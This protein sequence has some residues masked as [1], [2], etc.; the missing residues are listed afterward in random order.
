MTNNERLGMFAGVATKLVYNP[1]T[2]TDELMLIDSHGGLAGHWKPDSD[3]N[4][5]AMCEAKMPNDKQSEYLFT[6]RRIVS[7]FNDS[8]LIDVDNN[9]YHWLEVVA[10]SAS[11]RVE[12]MIRVLDNV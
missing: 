2:K 12:A 5:A 9:E 1:N 3:L 6:L 8:E 10:A 7:G 11:Q 4:Q